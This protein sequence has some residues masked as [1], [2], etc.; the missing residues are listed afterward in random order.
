MADTNTSEAEI[1]DEDGDKAVDGAPEEKSRRGKLIM[2]LLIGLLVVGSA[3]G[4]AFVFLSGRDTVVAEEDA[5]PVIEVPRKLIYIDLEP[6]FIQV[7]STKGILQN[8][9][10][11][12]ALE[13]EQ[14]SDAALRVESEMPRL[15]EAYLRT[16]N[17]RP[18]PGAAEGNVEVTHIKNR[19]SAE[20]LRILGPGAVYDVVLRNI[21]VTEG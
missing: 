19:I 8:V 6:I 10:V 21:W 7:V 5:P 14:G 9:V 2:F 15:Y 11:A 3:A 4:G 1:L 20:N 13:V 18:L 16:L 17:D 12:L